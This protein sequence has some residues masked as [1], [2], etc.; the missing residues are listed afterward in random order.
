MKS[1]FIV[2]GFLALAA[3]VSSCASSGGT[4]RGT[5]T[6]AVIT[7]EEAAATNQT[8]AF[9]V[10]RVLRPSWLQKRGVQSVRVTGDVV[11]YVDGM[12]MGGPQALRQVHVNAIRE[13]RHFDAS[14]ATQRWGTGH[15]F[16]AI[17][18]STR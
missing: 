17:A 15:G 4:A 6:R 11:V 2:V 13:I 9:D 3:S 14:S 16:G 12:H 7:A 10:V 18:V 5:S 1:R 8:T